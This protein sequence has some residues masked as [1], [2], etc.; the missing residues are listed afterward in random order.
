MSERSIF[1]TTGTSGDGASP[2]TQADLFSWLKRTLIRSVTTE[3]VHPG[4]GGELAPTVSSNTVTIAAGAALVNGIPYENTSPL[5][6]VIPVPTLGTTGHR[7]VLRADYSAHTVRITHL[8]S[9]DG[10]A[11]IPNKEQADNTRWDIDV[12]SLT[13][14]TGGVISLTDLRQF[15]HFNSKVS[16]SNLDNDSVDDTKVGARVPQ[17]VKRQ[18]GSTTNW[19]LAGTTTYTPGAVVQ[20]AGAIQVAMNGA[21]GAQSVT[22]PQPFSQPPIVFLTAQDGPA[23]LVVLAANITTTGFLIQAETNSGTVYLGVSVSWLAIG[24]E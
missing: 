16:N 2:Y 21:S 19:S 17:F 12:C 4:V 3:G 24:A 23:A 22:F 5:A 13:I 9:N 15:L 1:W 18:G 7:I 20:Q 11:V 6:V 8:A 14:T 10:V